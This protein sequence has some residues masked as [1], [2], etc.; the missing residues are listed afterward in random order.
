MTA[1]DNMNISRQHAKI[2][3]NFE[4]GRVPVQLK[5][6]LGLKLLLSTHFPIPS[7]TDRILSVLGTLRRHMGIARAGQEWRD[8]AGNSAHGRVTASGAALTGQDPD[9]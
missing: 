8:S 4:R 3:Y 6:N 9:C 5:R 2:Q 7:N 1:G